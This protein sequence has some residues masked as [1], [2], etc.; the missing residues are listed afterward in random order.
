MKQFLYERLTV[1]RRLIRWLCGLLSVMLLFAV[2]P[3]AADGRTHLRVGFYAYDGYHAIAEDGTRSGY[4]Y[5][6]LQL[7][8]RYANID[9]SYHGYE[10]SMDEN[11]LM[12][13][14]GEIDL[15]TSVKWTEERAQKFDYSDR[16]IGTISTVMT[17]KQG[18]TSIVNGD[19]STYN[20]ILLGFLKGSPRIEEFAAYSQ[21]KGFTYQ[22]VYFDTTQQM[23]EA[24]QNG[25]VDALAS[26]SMR[27]VQNEWTIDSFNEAPIYIIVR[28]GDRQTLDL[29]NHVLDRMEIEELN[30]RHELQHRYHTSGQ[31]PIPLLTQA[32][33]DY[34]A[35]QKEA[36]YVYTVLVNPDRYPY[37]Y[38]EDG[39]M[40]GIMADL[41]DLIA[42]RAG[43][44]YEWLLPTD[45]EDY[46]QRMQKGEADI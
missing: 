15:L 37:S 12:L 13:E 36:G 10:N 32:E 9:Y 35:R 7:L 11:M 28:K 38:I 26:T 34:L 45:R 30:W 17:V 18:N 25:E 5:D 16:S 19:Y 1:S 43:I 29:V 27:L 2:T 6:L 44:D 41:F 21:E 33:R 39:Q 4:G 14:R 8:S 40:V 24:L 31:G 46:A 22:S 42:Q 3:A 23:A 20:G